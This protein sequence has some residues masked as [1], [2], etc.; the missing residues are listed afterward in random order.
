MF[1]VEANA[2]GIAACE[3]SERSGNGRNAMAITLGCSQIEDE[4]VAGSWWAGDCECPP[5]VGRSNDAKFSS[6]D[7]RGT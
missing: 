4:Q 1:T 3:Q 5:W 2:D 7:S 6:T